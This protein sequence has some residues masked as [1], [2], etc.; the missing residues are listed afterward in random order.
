MKDW[1]KLFKFSFL[2]FGYNDWP[3]PKIKITNQRRIYSQKGHYGLI[4]EVNMNT[5]TTYT[6]NKSNHTIFVTFEENTLGL[7]NQ[8][9]V[10]GIRT[11][12]FLFG[13]LTAQELVSFGN[14]F[15]NFLC[16]VEKKIFDYNINKIKRTKT[17]QIF[18][19]CKNSKFN[20]YG[21]WNNYRSRFCLKINSK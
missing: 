13:F 6:R 9:N 21:E 11:H 3:R 4:F 15:E 1:V 16:N 18:F 8:Y 19:Y 2:K 12:W 5:K 7:K 17:N 10:F 20:F 14:L